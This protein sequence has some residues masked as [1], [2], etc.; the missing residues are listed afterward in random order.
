MCILQQHR[1][2][3]TYPNKSRSSL[4]TMA[5]QPLR[6]QDRAP[7]CLPAAKDQ[8][9]RIHNT[10]PAS[11]KAMVIS[12]SGMTKPGCVPLAPCQPNKKSALQPQS[13]CYPLPITLPQNLFSHPNCPPFSA[14]TFLPY[15][16]LKIISMQSTLLA[17]KLFIPPAGTGSN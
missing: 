17:T 14:F 7:R 8:P 15:K 9:G 3:K 1:H 2:K 16:R 6:L 10:Q 4:F 11:Q 12:H 13:P 5:D